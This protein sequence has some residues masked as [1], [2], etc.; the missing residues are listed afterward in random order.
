M[1]D[2]ADQSN[3]S[4]VDIAS[5]VA[6]EKYAWPGGYELFA[7]TDDGGILC[8][9]CCKVEAE[10]IAEAFEGDGFYVTA[11]DHMGNS[12]ESERCDHC[13]RVIE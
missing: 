9:T 5:M 3:L 11:F 8:H 10:R 6:R 12:D 7:M 13:G 1:T 2:K 4:P